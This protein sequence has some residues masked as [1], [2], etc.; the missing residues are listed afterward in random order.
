MDQEMNRG[1]VDLARAEARLPRWMLAAALVGTIAI[2]A[3]G[4]LRWALGFSVG[5]TLAILNYYWLH[6]GITALFDAGTTRIP[7]RVVAKFVLRYPLT[8][9]GIYVF[10]RAGWLPFVWVLA[11]LFVPAVGILFEA[12]L[13]VWQAFGGNSALDQVAVKPTE[14]G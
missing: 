14:N 6:D 5:A 8:F 11:G 10:Y 12:V 7:K 3:S 13:Q 1:K 2:L 4:H 9:A